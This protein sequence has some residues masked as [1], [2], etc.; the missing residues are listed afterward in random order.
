MSKH[1]KSPGHKLPGYKKQKANGKK[2][3]KQTTVAAEIGAAVVRE[4]AP[5][6]VPAPVA[7]PPA[8]VAS[9]PAPAV[10]K[11][12]AKE[13]VPEAPSRVL[14]TTVDTFER[15]FKAV[16]QGTIAVNRKL[17]DFARANVSSGLDFAMSLASATS[18]MEIM[19]LQMNYW[20][21]RRKVLA[22]QAE[23]LRALSADLMVKTNEQIR[24]H[25]RRA[26]RA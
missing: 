4:E 25:M 11:P 1:R 17:I 21:E 12:V 13:E 19:Q 26:N 10:A 14:D 22:S 6:P 24:Q 18:P 20:D 5:E 15:S 7:P 16:G 2:E 9:S 8:S 3:L 23:E